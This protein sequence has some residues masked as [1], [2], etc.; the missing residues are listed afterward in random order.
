MNGPMNLRTYFKNVYSL[1]FV[2]MYELRIQV[3]GQS[4]ESNHTRARHG[5]K[6]TA[7]KPMNDTLSRKDTA[8]SVYACV[9]ARVAPPCDG[10]VPHDRCIALCCFTPR[11]LHESISLSNRAES[12][13]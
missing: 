11:T 7:V 13:V 6:L 3:L 1:N 4:G 12:D 9:R 10:K 8:P 2:K 5:H